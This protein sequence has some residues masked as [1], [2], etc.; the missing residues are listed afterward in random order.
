MSRKTAARKRN[1][2]GE[3]VSQGRRRAVV[4]GSALRLGSCPLGGAEAKGWVRGVTVSPTA[5]GGVL[6]PSL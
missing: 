2:V 3:D 1:A 5:E 6:S 4:E